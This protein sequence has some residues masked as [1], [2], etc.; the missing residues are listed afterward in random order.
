MDLQ[1]QDERGGNGDDIENLLQGLRAFHQSN[2]LGS[3]SPATAWFAWGGRVPFSPENGTA[4]ALSTMEG[5]VGRSAHGAHLFVNRVSL[6]HQG[7]GRYV[8]Q[9]DGKR[10][11][12]ALLGA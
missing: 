8:E 1:Q 10:V 6:L 5:S 2:M 11:G 3:F 4:G 7:S 12:Q 9:H